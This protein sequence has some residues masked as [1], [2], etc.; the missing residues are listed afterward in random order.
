M[1]KKTNKKGGKELSLKNSGGTW[2][3]YLCKPYSKNLGKRDTSDSN[4][5]ITT[6][7]FRGESIRRS[8]RAHLVSTKPRKVGG[9]TKKV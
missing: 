1:D 5:D 8:A 2:E 9:E 6:L 4:Y 7:K 3:P